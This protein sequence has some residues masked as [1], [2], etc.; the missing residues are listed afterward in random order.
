[1]ST[2]KKSV[3]IVQKLIRQI[4]QLSRTI[5]KK[6][7]SFLL[8]SLLVFG[9]RSRL[10]RAGF[11]L[12]TVVMVMLVVVLLT[13]AVVFRSFDRSR[14]ISNYRVNQEVLNAALPALDRAKAK[15]EALFADPNLPRGTPSDIPIDSVLKSNTYNLPD[16]ERLMLRYDLPGGTPNANR[17]DDPTLR[18]EDEAITT[19]AWRFPVDSDNNGKN[20]SFTLYSILFRTPNANAAGEFNRERVPLEARA[21]PMTNGES[22]PNCALASGTSASLVGASGWYKTGSQLKRSFFIYVT[23]VP[24]TDKD[25]LGLDEPDNYENYTGNKGFSA[26]EYQQDRAKFPLSNNAVL[27]EDD[28]DI[29]SGGEL[30]LNGRIFTNSN[31][32]IKQI[33]T[34]KPITLRQ[35]S[36]R[37]SCFYEPENSKIVVG[38]NVAYGR[39]T[40]AATDPATGNI[41]V[42]LYQ[43][44]RTTNDP[45]LVPTLSSANQSVE[46]KPSAVAYNSRAYEARIAKLVELGIANNPDPSEVTD[47]VNTQLSSPNP[48]TADDARRKEIESYFRNRT[49]RVPFTEVAFGTNEDLSSV[50]LTGSGDTLGPPREWIYPFDPADGKTASGYGQ[51]TLNTS[52]NK[53]LPPATQFETQ[54]DTEKEEYIGDRVLIGNNLPARWLDGNTWVGEDAE[55]EIQ[56]TVWDN[57]DQGPRTRKARVEVLSD[58]GD[59]S[60]D[61]FWERK[62]AEL[63]ENSLDGIGGVRIV[64]GAGIYLPDDNAINAASRVV[65]PDTM[66]VIPS[67]VAIDPN[68]PLKIT[69]LTDFPKDETSIKRPFLKMR[70]TA[71]Y[72]YNH[73]QGKKPIACVSSFYDPTNAQTVVNRIDP[74]GGTTPDGANSVNGITYGPPTT[75]EGAVLDYLNYEADL[76]YPNG[77]PVNALLKTALGTAADARTLA[78]Q[79][80]I[81]ATICGLQIYGKTVRTGFDGTWGDIGEPT[82]TPTAG[83]QLPHETI[84]EVAFLDG[85]QIKAITGQLADEDSDPATP[86]TTDYTPSTAYDLALEQR[87]P[88]EIRVTQLNLENLRTST[89]GELITR[90]GVTGPEEHMLPLSGIIYATRDDALADASDIDALGITNDKVAASDFLLDFKR[91]PNGIMLIN[92]GRL[93]RTHTFVEQEKGLILASNLPVYVKAEPRVPGDSLG[94]FN[95]HQNLS[96]QPQEEFNDTTANFYAREDAN[97]F[98]ACRAGDPRLSTCT[99]SDTWRPATI[100]SDAVTLL[101]STFREGN[102]AEGDYDLRNNQIDIIADTDINGT[103]DADGDGTDDLKAASEIEKARLKNGFWNNDFVTN[104]LSSEG[105]TVD[106]RTPKDADY[107]NTTA[108]TTYVGSSYFNNFVTPVQR[109]VRFP[110][111]VMEICRKL[112]VSECK[113]ED[114]VVGYDFD[115]DGLLPPAERDIKSSELAEKFATLTSTNP[116]TQLDGLEVALL[117]AGTT[118]RAAKLPEDRRYAR[119]IAFLRYPATPSDLTVTTTSGEVNTTSPVAGALVLHRTTA[120]APWTPVPLGIAGLDASDTN[121]TLRYYPYSTTLKIHWPI[122]VGTTGID[123]F[124]YS[125]TSS[126]RPRLRA[127]TLWYRGQNGTSKDYGYLYPLDYVNGS[128]SNTNTIEDTPALGGTAPDEQPLL[129]PV[130][131]LHVTQTP[132]SFPPSLPSFPG[133]PTV[134]FT[135]W[136]QQADADTIFNLVMATG[137]NP[138]RPSSGVGDEGEF[139]GGL[140]NLPRFLENWLKTAST[141]TRFLSKIS[142]SLIQIKRSSYA[143]APFQQVPISFTGSYSSSL[144]PGGP[145]GYPQVYNTGNSAGRTPA[146][147]AP[148][149]EWGFDVGVLSQLPDLFSKQFTVPLTE[150]P[151]EF[152][153]E[154]GR[155]DDWIETLLC[156][157]TPDNSIAINADQRP[158]GFCNQHTGG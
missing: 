146:Y 15:I 51:L 74:D 94:G 110:E 54:E 13:S 113:P 121:V 67:E 101:S 70:A 133:T 76:V 12:P 81:D 131:Q 35:V 85:R 53:L 93:E 104:G 62:A 34:S 36:S 83:Y 153:R 115:G 124:S 111:Y 46:Q 18:I 68:D 149:R 112:P 127:N 78:Q 64:T 23:T 61:G 37:N 135:R 32:F 90:T 9:R 158:S 59:I 103:A 120:S 123:Y 47:A 122:L 43:G 89:A 7:M 29:S 16:E 52:G 150:K 134:G 39:V 129:V 8:R 91:R 40:D 41:G 108:S 137:D 142:G 151:N 72:A 14:N 69:W 65:W 118:S 109:R 11:V 79:A 88:L 95:S 126:R 22:S 31:L 128:D 26:L 154:V 45:Y 130:L 50:T 6:L 140:S 100:L 75:T 148:G 119:R 87:Q 102:R 21:L 107:I 96:G 147:E 30:T 2:S 114:W 38:G 156:A 98:F 66:P 4:L 106:G 33:T 77:R 157:K 49:R 145:F 125:N 132:T 1:M 99:D 97:P 116:F 71:V 63:P 105:I 84:K 48:P 139:N 82:T 152:F 17:E 28:L 60:R 144:A 19:H 5:T 44:D 58:L 155:D 25:S 117:G 55:Q 57:P 10:S 42:H 143:T 73:E 80:A 27:Y 24:I 3:K 138:S 86:E 92:G 56:G 20:D 136:I 141:D